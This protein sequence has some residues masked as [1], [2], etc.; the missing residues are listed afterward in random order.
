MRILTL[1]L[2]LVLAS[3][4]LSLAPKTDDACFIDTL[5]AVQDA[6]RWPRKSGRTKSGGHVIEVPAWSPEKSERIGRAFI[7]SAARHDYRPGFLTGFAVNES[8]LKDD[9]VRET[10]TKDGRIAK[11]SGLM[12]VRCILSDEKR[13]WKGTH[14]LHRPELG[15]KFRRAC[16][17]EPVRGMTIEEILVPE[18]NIEIATTE[19][20]RLRDEGVP[21]LVSRIEKIHGRPRLVREV[22]K[23]PH[24][25]HPYFAH[26]NWGVRVIDTGPP[27]HYPQ[28]IAVLYHFIA[29]AMGTDTPELDGVRFVQDKGSKPRR[30]DKPVGAR[31]RRLCEL[32]ATC[33]GHCQRFAER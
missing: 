19:L 33:A 17:N 21:L 26:F 29:E 3:P 23:C 31:Q 18:T 15:A 13:W 30:V 7:D 2:E 10:R 9:A 12:A 22:K 14:L 6:I 27:R 16:T 4:D 5:R 25:N 1:L 24:R 28:R 11:D 8:D 32:I 20:A